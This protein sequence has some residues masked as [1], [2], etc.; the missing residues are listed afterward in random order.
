LTATH[1]VGEPNTAIEPKSFS[2]NCILPQADWKDFEMNVFER[3][4]NVIISA[5]LQNR[6][7][8]KSSTTWQIDVEDIYGD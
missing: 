6:A 5:L 8:L 2:G 4:D 3:I 1:P 7:L